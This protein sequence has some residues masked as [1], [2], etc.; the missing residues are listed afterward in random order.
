MRLTKNKWLWI[1]CLLLSIGLPLNAQE[2]TP[3]VNITLHVW[4]PD[5]LVLP[6]EPSM[7]GWF[8]AQSQ[9]FTQEQIIE[10]ELRL[11]STRVGGNILA[12]LQTASTVAPDA[13][14]ELTLLRRSD[15]LIA[16]Q[17]GLIQSIDSGLPNDLLDDIGKNAQ[18]CTIGTRLYGVPLAVEVLHTVYLNAAPINQWTYDDII[19]RTTPI[20]M[21]LGDGTRAS[22][23]ALLQYLAGDGSLNAPLNLDTLRPML[24]FYETARNDQLLDATLINITEPSEYFINLVT[25][26]I[27]QAVVTSSQFLRL[28]ALDEEYRPAPIPTVNGEKITALDG[29]CWVLVTDDASEQAS[30]LR[31]ITFMLQEARMRDMVDVL[32]VLPSRQTVMQSFPVQRPFYEQLLDNAFLLPNAEPIMSEELQNAIR[33]VLTGEQT[34]DEVLRNLEAP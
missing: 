19:T 20:A 22:V 34:V 11:R 26:D 8:L 13:M 16:Q 31:Y 28:Q 24:E 4:L 5:E 2:S 6:E 14:P 32:G 23:V 12:T 3:D 27:S 25:G 29:W 15:L 21:P 9:A 18:I 17:S 1:L 30:A 7:V 33:S 10:I